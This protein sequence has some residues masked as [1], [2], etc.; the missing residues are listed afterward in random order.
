MKHQ[1]QTPNHDGDGL[2]PAS[3]L[4]LACEHQA[5]LPEGLQKLSTELREF[6]PDTCYVTDAALLLENPTGKPFYKEGNTPEEWTYLK[7]MD[8]LGL[9]GIIVH[10]P[11]MKC[12]YQKLPSRPRVRS[13]RMFSVTFDWMRRG[14]SREQE[15]QVFTQLQEICLPYRAYGGKAFLCDE[16]YN[17]LWGFKTLE[18]A[19]YLASQM[20]VI[21]YEVC[22]LE[23]P[24]LRHPWFGTKSSPQG[25]HC[26]ITP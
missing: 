2:L 15:D 22:S 17:V 14:T 3:V 19:L 21:G 7:A 1:K 12:L 10:V 11:K 5:P 23:K 26:G 9:P 13:A 4:N 24:R 8:G 25:I 6:L 16:S 18:E 20:S